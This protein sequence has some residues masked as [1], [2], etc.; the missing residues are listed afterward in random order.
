MSDAQENSAVFFRAN[1]H[2]IFIDEAKPPRAGY[3][4]ISPTLDKVSNSQNTHDDVN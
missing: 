3:R 4:I 2:C 1:L